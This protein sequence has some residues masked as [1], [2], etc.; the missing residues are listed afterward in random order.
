MMSDNNQEEIKENFPDEEKEGSM[1]EGSL[2]CVIQ[3][4]DHDDPGARKTHYKK[5][6]E[7]LP[8]RN[9]FSSAQPKRNQPTTIKNQ[10][11]RPAWR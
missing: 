11:I 4:R 2:T 8:A 5:S 9:L 10:N 6:A 7:V 3:K 1:S